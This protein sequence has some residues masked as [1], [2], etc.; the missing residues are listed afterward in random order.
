MPPWKWCRECTSHREFG[1]RLGLD[2][3]ADNL[4]IVRIVVV[5]FLEWRSVD[6]DFHFQSRMFVSHRHGL[7]AGKAVVMIVCQRSADFSCL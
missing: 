2:V 1:A 3:F 7:V 5:V 6:N 4:L